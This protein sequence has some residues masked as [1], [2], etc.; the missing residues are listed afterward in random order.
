VSKHDGEDALELVKIVGTDIDVD[1]KITVV[2][3][4]EGTG[5][6]VG[7]LGPVGFAS[8]GVV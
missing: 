1:E 7:L 3:V 5:E 6:V 4:G 2:V 8:G